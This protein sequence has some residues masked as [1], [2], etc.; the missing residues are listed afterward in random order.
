MAS[1]TDYALDGNPVV[2]IQYHPMSRKTAPTVRSLARELGIAP[3]TVSRALRGHPNVRPVLAA[4]VRRLASRRG[5]RLDPVVSEVMGGL[6]RAQ[7]VRYRE[8]VAFVWTHQRSQPDAEQSGAQAVAESLG[9]RMEII[10]PWQEG[11]DDRDVSRILWARGIRGVLLAPN[12]S[13][14][15]PRYD[16]EWEKFAV[17]LVGSSLVNTRLPRI[18]RD[19]FHDAKLAMLKMREAG[20]MRTGL[21]LSASTHHRTDRRYAAAAAAYGDGRQGRLHFVDSTKP[22][23]GERARFERWISRTKPEALL[24]DFPQARAWVPRDLPHAFLTLGAGRSGPG[25]RADFV[26]VGAEAM[27]MLDGMLRGGRLGLQSE[28][29]SLLVP[30]KWVP[31]RL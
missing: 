6:G 12:E 10:K 21:A 1:G 7:G 3:M 11:L 4:K 20:R 26:R 24:T 18:S 17:V 5:Y 31:G 19:Y 23:D 28:P 22:E 27:R 25:V 15:D 13:R 9:Y 30:G 16:L 14:P 8:T 2:M 29:V